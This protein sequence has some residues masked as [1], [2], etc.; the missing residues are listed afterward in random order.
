MLLM[1]YWELWYI[2]L[3]DFLIKSAEI[4]TMTFRCESMPLEPLLRQTFEGS[5]ETLH[6]RKRQEY[7]QSAQKLQQPVTFCTAIN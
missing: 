5:T 7:L 2:A 6:N 3:W 1:E 4:L